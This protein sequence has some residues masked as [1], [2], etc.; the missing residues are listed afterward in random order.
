[1]SPDIILTIDEK[2][3]TVPAGAT[4]LAAANKLGIQIPTLCHKDGLEPFTSCFLCV[5]DIEGRANPAPACST[6]ATDG[7]VVQTQSPRIRETRKMCLELLLSDHCGDCIAPCVLTCPAGCNIQEFLKDIAEGR[8]D[9]AVHAIKEA[10]PIPGALGRICPRPCEAQCRRVRV[11]EP[12]AIGWLHRYAADENAA[13][14]RIHR[15]APGPDTGKIVAVIGAG[16]AGMAA[17]FFLRQFGHAV[18]VLEA[19]PEPGGMLRWGIPAYRLPR[20]SLGKEL[21]AIIE[22]GIE[23]RYDRVLGKD[24]SL[25]DLR[26]EGFHAIFMAVG[27]PYSSALQVEGETLP[28]VL[29]GVEFLA[30]SAHGKKM[31]IG[32]RVVVVG[33]GNTAIDAVRTARRLGAMEVTILYRRTR[34]EMPALPVE[35]QEAEREGV[36]FRFLAAPLAIRKQDHGL[37]IR[38]QQMKLGEPD[39]SGRRRPVPVSGQEFDLEADTVIA[40]IGQKIDAGMLRQ[41][42]L[43]LDAQG[44]AIRVN[45]ATMQTSSPDVFAGGDA[46]ACED[47]KIAVW[48]V[49]SGRLASIAIDQYLTGQ[50][51]VGRPAVFKMAMGKDPETITSRRFAGIEK[52]ERTPM[53]ELEPEDRV[54]NFREVELGLTPDVARG[55]ARRCLACGCGAAG[56]CVIRE[57]ALEYGADPDRFIG[58]RRDYTVNTE[59]P[60]IILEP[61]KCVN[62]GLCVR[63]GRDADALGIFG[64]VDRGFDTRIQPYFEFAANEAGKRLCLE[65][66]EACPTGAIL[67]RSDLGAHICFARPPESV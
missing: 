51:V 45:S 2:Q 26:R 56:D 34:T 13:G 24:F 21:N 66:A 31:H 50:P 39:A 10:L 3:V 19:Q 40:A 16:P 47:Q 43:E 55:E 17:A 65:C 41:E 64:F 62:C 35:V 59:H 36:R 7:M 28:G 54:T 22:M 53:R 33:G 44:T 8:N 11:E 18:T 38:C 61:G 29:G 48:A 52:N 20:E 58:A 63:L 42:G 23:M 1:M 12:L 49:G 6:A 27:A 57:Y 30:R 37:A 4:I 60:D 32:K 14:G 15:P 46:V 67:K 5:V 9:D 25:A